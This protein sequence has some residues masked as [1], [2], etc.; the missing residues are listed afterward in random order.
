[1]AESKVVRRIVDDS[2]GGYCGKRFLAAFFLWK[3]AKC[4]PILV[5][6]GAYLL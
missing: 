5:D 3:L 2:H 1:M 4:G 6:G